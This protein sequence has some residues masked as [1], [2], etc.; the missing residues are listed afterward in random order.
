MFSSLTSEAV[1]SSSV[2]IDTGAILAGRGS[3]RVHER[4][5]DLA[6]RGCL[7]DSGRSR[8]CSLMLVSV[9]LAAWLPALT[10]SQTLFLV[11][12]FDT[13]HTFK[14]SLNVFSLI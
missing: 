9:A 6:F 1:I 3:T 14:Q 7:M 5:D 13:N 8:D 12:E 4:R 10:F 11:P 2:A